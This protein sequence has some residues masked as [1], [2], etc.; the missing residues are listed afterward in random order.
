MQPEHHRPDLD[1]ADAG[2]DVQRVRQRDAGIRERRN[3]R[4][5]RACVD[6]DRVSA[7]RLDDRHSGSADLLRQILR[8]AD[9][10][11]E[12]W[13]VDDLFESARD[14]LEVVAGEPAVRR[15]PFG[16]DQQ[17]AALAR[18]TRRCSSRG[19]RRCSRGR[20]SWPT[21]CSR[22]RGRTSPGRSPAACD[23]PYP[24]S[25]CLMNHAF[26]ANRQAS[27]KNGLPYRSHERAHGAQVRRATPAG[28]RRS[29]SS[30]S[31]SRAERDR[32]RDRARP[33]APRCPCCL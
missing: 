11:P 13:L 16:Q 8:G 15:K 29:C 9:A 2:L 6:V 32:H 1:A 12:I 4:Q 7:R 30:P 31:P 28:R 18:P 25:R 27:R 19:S 3:V 24:S 10:V 23:R 14:R 5:Q 17:V 33:R 21:S 26:S 20:P 22:R